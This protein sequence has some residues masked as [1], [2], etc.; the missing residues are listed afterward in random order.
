[1]SVRGMKLLAFVLCLTQYVGCSRSPDAGAPRAPESD[2]TEVAQVVD[3]F[4]SALTAGDSMAAFSLLAEDA[5][6][7][8][9]GGLETLEEYRSHHLPGDIAFAQAVTRERR[10]IRVE[11]RGDVAW[12]VSTSITTGEFRGRQINSQGAELMV[13]VRTDRGGWRISAIHWSS[14]AR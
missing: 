5:L 3:A 11:V 10:R 9:S 4:H 14:R 12:A 6:I 7:L 8:E 13:L 2:S 1:M